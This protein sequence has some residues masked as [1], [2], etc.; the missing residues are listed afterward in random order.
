MRQVALVV[1]VMSALFLLV[2]CTSSTNPLLEKRKAQVEKFMTYYETG[3]ESAKDAIMEQQ[4]FYEDY[5]S[6]EVADVRSELIGQCKVEVLR[7]IAD[8]KAVFAQTLLRG[9]EANYVSYDLFVFAEGGV[10]QHWYGMERLP[11]TDPE[12]KFALGGDTQVKDLDKTEANKALVSEFAQLLYEDFK[13]STLGRF[14][15]NGKLIRHQYPPENNFKAYMAEQLIPYNP[16][17]ALEEA[18]AGLKVKVLQVIGEGNFVMVAHTISYLFSNPYETLGLELFRVEN[19]KI[20]E[21]WSIQQ[22]LASE[23][24]DYEEDYEEEMEEY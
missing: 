11:P 6:C 20:V 17:D 16:T 13:H 18:P 23:E 24:G 14:F 3:D 2:G 15:D 9:R 5:P 1:V 7:I 12:G 19:G 21:V 8:D 10:L 22:E 4:S